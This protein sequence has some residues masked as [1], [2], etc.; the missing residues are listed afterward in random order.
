MGLRAL[1]R[2]TNGWIGVNK[3]F[4]I[5]KR[6]LKRLLHNPV[7]I[8][9]TIGV[10][11][12]PS[13]YAWYNIVANWDPYAN[14]GNI[15]IAVA[16]NDRGTENDLAGDLNAG[17]EVIEKLRENDDLGWTFVDA[18]EAREGV[19]RGDYYAAI[20]IPK[21]FSRDLT[22][23]LTGTFTEPKITYYV[24]EKKNA[25]APKVTDTGAETIEE[26][27]NDTFVATV[28]ETFVQL[29]HDA[30][31]SLTA[32]GD[33]AS[34]SLV[35]TVGAASRAVADVRS[36]MRDLTGTISDA[37]GAI[38]SADKALAG[39]SGQTPSLTQ[40]LQQGDE[41]L[42]STRQTARDFTASLNTALSDGTAALGSA[43]S[44][45]NAAV[46]KIS[47]TLSSVSTSIYIS[48][49]NIDD[50][51]DHNN[52]A[53]ERLQNAP[54]SGDLAGVQAIIDELTALNAELT[55][56]RDGLFAQSEALE[57]DG[58]AASA[59]AEAIDAA[60]QDGVGAVNRM[61]STLNSTTLPQLS[62]GLDAF[63]DVSGD[64]QAVVAGLEPTI[65]QAR[66]M[67]DQLSAT[68]DQATT[69]LK[70]MDTA[71]EKMGEKLSAASTDIAALG[72]SESMDQLAD[73]LGITPAEAADFMS[74][75]VKLTTKAVYPVS[76]YGSGVAPFYTNLALWV[77]GF[78]LIAIL[79]L[80]VDTEGVGAFTATQG[81]FGRW[82]LLV[83]LGFVQAVIVCVGDLV[84]GVQCLQPVLFVLAGVLTSFVYVNIIYALA[85]A[86][87]HIGKALAVVLVIVQ[88]PGSS[89]MYPIEMMPGFYQAIHPFLPFTYGINAMR[90]TIGG[91]YGMAYL[92]NLAVL[93]AFLAVAL[94]IGV[95]LRP[96][97]LNLNLLF[98]RQLASTGVMICE[99]NDLPRERFSLRYAL[100]AMLDVADFRE[101]L[102]ARAA[103]FEHRYPYLI[104]LGFCL[105]FGLP[106]VLFILTAMLDLT[107]DGKIVMLVLWIASIVLADAY[108]IVVEY[109][110]ESLNV[111]MRLASLSD[112]GLREEIRERTA[113]GRRLFGGQMGSGAET[114]P[115]G[116]SPERP[117]AA[118]TAPLG[119][120]ARGAHAAGGTDPS[121]GGEREGGSAARP[122]RGAHAKRDAES[123]KGGEA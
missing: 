122:A 101:Q 70:H 53:I 77:G 45:A 76:N 68:L 36:T 65:A 110:R 40:A 38:A 14:T 9:I 104:K 69:S 113:V 114:G 58:S 11:I 63:S 83:A 66:G 56:L 111:Q 23:M 27:V 108:M 8:V 92:G 6:D 86:F 78:V 120:S 84:L 21:D 28:A 107:I 26:Q 95:W 55:G 123:E 74:S 19:E 85:I 60:V 43:S 118:A 102:L 15:K 1:P 46:G 18:D 87:K 24:N 98:D 119:L 89:G 54:G 115:V 72:A 91:M 90:E 42:A 20:I 116:P 112:E 82:I 35:G 41:L 29:A 30:D 37:K 12:I 75:P 99:E 48:G 16:S 73:T 39:L 3:A 79:K 13:L 2:G 4:Q 80:E 61:Q 106:V 34:A 25:I 62:S 97:L 96:A 71:L 109:I 17:D 22:S 57:N 32:S 59:A 105:V 7:A 100:R 50:L 47:G 10:C 81:Y 93:G 94:F 64:L 52:A 44:K 121:L 31:A 49:K 5:F 67:L 51:I 117:D 88:I 33:E 103:R